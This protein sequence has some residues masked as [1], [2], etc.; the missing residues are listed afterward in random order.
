MQSIEKNERFLKLLVYPLL[1][2]IFLSLNQF[3][4]LNEYI[5][6]KLLDDFW[7]NVE[8]CKVISFMVGSTYVVERGLKYLQFG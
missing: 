6:L 2:G 3:E 7:K 1:M 5:Q 4:F 8:L